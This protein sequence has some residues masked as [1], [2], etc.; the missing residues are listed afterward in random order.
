MQI[1]YNTSSDVSNGNAT[2][3]LLKF[4]IWC[5]FQKIEPLAPTAEFVRRSCLA[6]APCAVAQ[7]TSPATFDLAT[8]GT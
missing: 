4:E 7:R 6:I 2:K 5:T 3:R 8:E 1:T